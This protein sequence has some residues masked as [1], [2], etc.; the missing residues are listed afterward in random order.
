MACARGDYLMMQMHDTNVLDESGADYHPGSKLVSTNAGGTGDIELQ[1][2]SSQVHNPNYRFKL[3]GNGYSDDGSNGQ[4]DDHIQLD[5][6]TGG[7]LYRDLMPEDDLPQIP[8]AERLPSPCPQDE[9]IITVRRKP[10]EFYNSYDWNAQLS[11]AGFFAAPVTCFL[12]APA[13]DMWSDIGIGMK[14]EG[15]CYT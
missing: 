15:K 14:V 12:H 3:S 8:K 10:S 1:L 11:N 2:T 13:Y 6:S 4:N 7:V 9:K 5:N